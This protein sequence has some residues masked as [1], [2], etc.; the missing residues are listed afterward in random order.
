MVRVAQPKQWSDQ[1]ARL[2]ALGSAPHDLAE[3]K[4]IS[5]KRQ[6][7]TVLFESGYGEYDGRVPTERIYSRPSHVS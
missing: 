1:H 6:V 4:T 5:E 2:Q 3:Q 7:Q